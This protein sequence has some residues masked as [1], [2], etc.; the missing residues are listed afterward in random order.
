M[1]FEIDRPIHFLPQA[2]YMKEDFGYSSAMAL[3]QQQQHSPVY[4]PAY[5]VSSAQ[6]HAGN[7]SGMEPEGAYNNLPSSYHHDQIS[8]SSS[9]PSTSQVPVSTSLTPLY[10]LGSSYSDMG[11]ANSS[12]QSSKKINDIHNRDL[13][14]P[15]PTNASLLTPPP[16]DMLQLH[17]NSVA[18]KQDMYPSHI[19]QPNTS[20]IQ[21]Q[22]DDNLYYSAS[23]TPRSLSN[24]PPQP[25]PPQLHPLNLPPCN[26]ISMM[27]QYNSSFNGMPSPLDLAPSPGTTKMPHSS[28]SQ[29]IKRSRY[30]RSPYQRPADHHQP[31]FNPPALPSSST[32]TSSSSSEQQQQH[33]NQPPRN[34]LASS[35]SS[36]SSSSTTENIPRRY[37]CTVCVKRFTRPSSLATHMHSHTGEKPYRCNV[38]G[39]GRRFSVVSNLRRHAKIHSHTMGSR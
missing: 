39:C 38:D 1:T 6:D 28:S 22:Q 33:T 15:L 24:S 31:S 2:N 7:K 9:S 32:S 19:E 14:S 3:T 35:S 37:K 29:H 16:L 25:Q 12:P 21:Q 34:R 13:L 20:W 36:S 30:H 5:N 10:P 23:T 11:A 18:W 4:S 17:P 26:C 8:S 27:P